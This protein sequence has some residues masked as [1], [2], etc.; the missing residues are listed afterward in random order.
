MGCKVNQYETGA[1]K[2]AFLSNGYE[3]VEQGKN[4]D[5]YI[6]NTCAVTNE[7][8]RKSKQMIRKAAR[9]N[10]CA[11]IVVTGCAVQSNLPDIKKC[12]DVTL[13]AGNYY[14]E[15]IFNILK[16][17]PPIS[18]EPKVLSGLPEEIINYNE[19]EYHSFSNRIRRLVKIQDG[20]NQFCSY[21]IIPYLRG[22]GRSRSAEQ[23]LSEIKYLADKGNKEVVLLGINL[24]SYGD[25]FSN[26]E[27]NL[28]ELISK[29]NSI[30]NI[31][32][33]RLSSIEPNYIT[34]ELVNAFSHYPKLC[35][36]L[37]IPL[38]SG[39]N[40]ILSLMHRKYTTA[41]YGKIIEYLKNIIPDIAITTDII[42]GFPGEDDKAFENT[43][44]MAKNCGFSKIHV[45]PYS[46]RT[47]NTA[48]FMPDKIEEKIIKNRS[49][50]LI[51][52]SNE[53][54]L[55]FIKSN[56]GKEKNVLIEIKEQKNGINSAYGL[57]DNFIKVYLNNVIVDKGEMVKVKILSTEN[58]YALGKIA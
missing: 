27:M 51:S 42:V 48:S 41:Q 53:L 17:I 44:A 55:A 58:N 52:L 2:Q 12:K 21:C 15:D 14:K 6:I 47:I 40:K 4:A 1:L 31:E 29:I 18:E 54:T 33:I 23:I 19:S 13:I 7:A 39:D 11:K 56:I 9:L 3:I 49:R 25:D 10:P 35:H 8:E 36:H 30:K 5:I 26:P 32:R 46:E 22:R 45:F 34:E 57:T 43:V 16:Q 50:Q 37:H 38:Q 20:C 24:G 28:I